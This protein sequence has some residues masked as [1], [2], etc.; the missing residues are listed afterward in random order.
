M[1]AK[2]NILFLAAEAEPFVKIG[3]L[4]DVAGSL[5]LALRALPYQATR[6]VT[7]D[8]RLV[9][10][11]HRA[12]RAEAT[13]LRPV[14]EFSVYRRG[15][16]IPA[17]VFEMS[18]DGMPV[19]F[20]NGDP[21]SS[22][23]SVY[24]SDL[25]ADRE[26]YA[27]FSLAAFELARHLGWQPDIVHAND[28]HTA[29][30]LYALRTRPDPLQAPL[31]TVF[32]IHNLPY[33]G[34]DGSD[35]LSAYGLMPLNDDSLPK[36]AQTQPLPLGLW[37]ADVI[38]PVSPSYAQEILTP[39]L[40]CGLDPYLKTRTNSMT[41]ILNGLDVDSWNPETD[42]TLAA[43]FTAD[44]LPARAVNKTAL[45]KVL[46]LKEDPQ[47]PLLVMIGRID[48]QK[49]LDIT[50]EA[51]R[52]MSDRS[53]QF[54]ILG[55]G[56]P[57]LENAARSLQADFPDRARAVIRYDAPLG[58]LLYGGADMFLMPSRYE[59]CGLA[60]MIAMRYGCVPVVRATGGLK[61]TVQEGRTGFLFQ[62]AAAGS[63]L[64]ALERALTVYARPEKWQNFQRNGLK[65]DFSWP[66]SA[67]QYAII[68]HS[69]VSGS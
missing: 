62:E 49:G 43:R 25:A 48:Q 52:Q 5:P 2:I 6:G 38:V 9:L 17:Q 68:Y 53:W 36:W 19:Y 67:R 22:S 33:M 37:S 32:T 35:V 42:Q 3:G 26:K 7:L 47:V 18:S 30:A 64:D 54:V 10:P 15:G 66:R 12:V 58:R 60:Q 13:T 63:M 21:L 34:G 65:E 44:E 51:L 50:F 40:G 24:S 1:S 31:H 4:A 45:Q 41:G 39:E 46:E 23:L 57:A 69:L 29:L 11:L 16:N 59:P 27:F 14:A 8:V 61:D 20:I 28:W 56:D 55:S